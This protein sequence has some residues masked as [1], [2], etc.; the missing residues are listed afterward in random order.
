[1]AKRIATPAAIP[2]GWIGAADPTKRSIGF[3]LK[4]TP[5]TCKPELLEHAGDGHLFT[6]APTGAG[7]G[8]SAVIPTL[9][10]YTGPVLVIDLKGE[11]Y[12]VTARRRRELGHRVVVLDPFHWISNEPD[13]LNP[14][15]IINLPGGQ[16][17]CDCELMAEL[18]LGGQSMSSR[19]V[20]WELT[21]KG[22]LTGLIGLAGELEP[23]KRNL[24]TAT[25][26]LYADD[27]DY[28]I[29]QMLD[30]HKFSNSLAREELVAYLSHEA[31]RCRPSVRST[32][33]AMVKALRSQAVR[34]A[35]SRTSF[36]L[37]AWFRG[38]P[39]DI[40]LIFPPDKLDSHRALLRLWMGTLLAV[41]LRRRE[42]TKSRTLLLIDEAAQ[43]GALPHL[44]TALTLLRGFGVQVWTFWQDLSQL[45]H[46]Y[47]NDWETILNNSAII[48]A[49]GANNGWVSRA[50]AEIL[51]VPQATVQELNTDEQLLLRPGQPVERCQRLDYLHD[52]IF[53]G[54]FDPNPRYGTSTQGK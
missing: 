32:A 47:P 15:D 54:R 23:A 7:K 17:D 27:T 51:G 19:D 37:L 36:D 14:Y 4:P 8:R 38:D 49:F 52:S 24:V 42:S 12:L 53:A 29:A 1:M 48:Q 22:M 10:T 18:L 9:L 6:A 50:I 45:K 31:D 5:V 41:L 30:T 40:Y 34:N 39:M 13:T 3:L 28:S 44:R 43:L 25:D 33:Q 21:G 35:L 2:L 26:F 20:F 16:P 46:L 11:N